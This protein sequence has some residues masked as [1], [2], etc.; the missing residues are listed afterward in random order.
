MVRGGSAG[1]PAGESYTGKPKHFPHMRN[2]S[3]ATAWGMNARVDGVFPKQ[4]TAPS[5]IPTI[6]LSRRSLVPSHETLRENAYSPP[7]EVKTQRQK[8]WTKNFYH[9]TIMG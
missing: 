6:Y 1:P 2:I 4:K 7:S 3:L 8:L 9:Y 5:P